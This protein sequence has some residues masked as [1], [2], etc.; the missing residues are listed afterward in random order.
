MAGKDITKSST[1]PDTN[2]VRQGHTTNGSFG[3]DP[4]KKVK[5]GRQVRDLT[6]PNAKG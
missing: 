1:S 3:S 2:I 5:G 4:S 6:V